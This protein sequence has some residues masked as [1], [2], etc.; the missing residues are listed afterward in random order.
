MKQQTANTNH[1]KAISNKNQSHASAKAQ[2]RAAQQRICNEYDAITNRF[3]HIIACVC[4]R[5][6]GILARHRFLVIRL[7]REQLLAVVRSHATTTT[8]T[9]SQYTG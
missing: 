3:H 9:K 7:C 8:T 6:I 4:K 1:L 2:R 5:I